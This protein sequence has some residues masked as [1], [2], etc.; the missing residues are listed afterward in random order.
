[1][2]KIGLEKLK[3][4][5][6]EEM[7]NLHEGIDHDVAA[8]ILGGASKLLNAIE[9]FK[10]TASEKVKAEMGSNLEEVEKILNRIADSPMQYVDATKPTARKVS[11]K[12]QKSSNLV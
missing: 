6:Q 8:K 11:L 12:P 3:K 1:M 2:S 9:A 10:N 7:I 5:I 4:I